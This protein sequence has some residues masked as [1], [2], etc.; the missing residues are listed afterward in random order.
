MRS[1]TVRQ[2]Q[3]FV[4]AAEADSFASAAEKLRV[5]P[6]AISFQVRQLESMSGFALFE[7]LGRQASLSDAGRVLLGY[8]RSVLR[9]LDDA[10]QSLTALRGAVGGR[11][12]IGLISTA[13][14]IVPHLL[15]RFQAD[16]PG[17]AI[18]LRD[19]NRREI[20]A[21][22]G[23][24]DIEIAV[25]GRPPDDADLVAKPFATHPSVVVAAPTHKLAGSEHTLPVAALANE[26]FI[27]REEGSGTRGLM[28]RF[29]GEHGVAFRQ[30]MTTSSNEMIKQA[31]M[32]GM[33]VAL[34]SRHT[35]GLEVA[36]DLLRVLPI[37]GTPLMRSWFVAHRRSLPLLPV[38]LKLRGFLLEHGQEVI[39]GLERG[40]G[41]AAVARGTAGAAA[42]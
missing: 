15:A 3:M 37:Q 7:R 31:V 24:G 36:L 26:R 23:K 19:G 4:A 40:Y 34:L 29:L 41:A 38:H 28:E 18:H 13:K 39:D 8:A 16:H 11:V 5:S 14:Y 42:A 12:T 1:V 10:D 35:V 32:A 30:G 27:L 25:M 22:L 33:G 21:A 9:S 17:V 6:A 20:A 2:L